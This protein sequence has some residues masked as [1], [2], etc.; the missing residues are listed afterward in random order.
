MFATALRPA[1]ATQLPRRLR[2][3]GRERQRGF[4]GKNGKSPSGR[5]DLQPE[6]LCGCEGRCLR[7]GE[8]HTQRFAS[9]GGLRLG[10]CG[11]LGG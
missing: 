7:A 6:G 8:R 10:V 1:R 11:A 2:A 4:D 9:L 3:P 5:K